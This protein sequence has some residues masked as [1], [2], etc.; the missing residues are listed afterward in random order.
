MRGAGVIQDGSTIREAEIERDT[1]R[2]WKDAAK[3]E[4][5]RN[6]LER[7][8]MIKERRENDDEWDQGADGRC[9]AVVAAGVAVATSAMADII[10]ED[11]T[12]GGSRSFWASL[13]D[14]SP[15]GGGGSEAATSSSGGGSDGDGGGS[16]DWPPLSRPRRA[17]PADRSGRRR[18]R[19]R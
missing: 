5:Y 2:F 14:G 12:A 8:G 19:G 10:D 7:R 16:S 11:R 18:A 6:L 1:P 15:D 3:R 13:F 9:R 4:A 17:P